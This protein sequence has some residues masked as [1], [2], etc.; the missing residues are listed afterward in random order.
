M[1]AF[2][3]WRQDDLKLEASLGLHNKTLFLKEGG[4]EGRGERKVRFL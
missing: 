2:R 3:G 1:P 4:K